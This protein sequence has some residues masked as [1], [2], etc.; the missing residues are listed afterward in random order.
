MKFW[1]KIFLVLIIAAGGVFFIYLASSDFLASPSREL[2]FEEFEQYK[3]EAASQQASSTILINYPA[4]NFELENVK[5]EKTKLSD[6]KNKIIILVFWTTWNPAAQDQIA[7]LEAYYQKIK[8]QNDIS[9]IT[10]NSQE[11]KSAAA[12]FLRRGEY[13]FPALLDEKGEIGE[14]YKISILPAFYFINKDKMVMD[15][16]IGI[17]SEEEIKERAAKLYKD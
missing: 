9:L 14:L 7:I 8:N 6:V 13:E 5:G 16:Y 10:V 3:K 11:D 15:K 12:S 2:P 4:P 17:L 1:L